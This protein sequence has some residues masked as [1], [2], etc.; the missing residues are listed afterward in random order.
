VAL[1]Y[2]LSALLLNVL[3]DGRIDDDE[4][5]TMMA[6]INKILY[7]TESVQSVEYKEKAFVLTGEFLYGTK[8]E[9]MDY[10]KEKGGNVLGNVSKKVDYVVIGNF[11][12]DLYGHG[13][14]GTKVKRAMELQEQGSAIIILHEDELFPKGE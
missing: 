6:T 10:I 9:V 8:T 13:T 1:F 14:Y 4:E 11:G 7:P 5:K 2:E 12:S 3:L